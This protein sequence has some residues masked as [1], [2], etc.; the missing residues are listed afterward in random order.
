MKINNM[1]KMGCV[2]LAANIY[3][4]KTPLNVMLSVTDRCTAHCSYCDIPG[5]GLKELDKQIL[6]DLINQICSLGCQRL[7]IWGGEPLVRQ[8]IG[9]IIDYAKNRRL[10]VTMDSNGH[11]LPQKMKEIRNLDHL[12]LSLDGPQDMHD[13]NRG[14]GSFQKVMTAI[15]VAHN[16]VPFWTITV[17]TKYNL[18]SIDFILE[19]ARKYN[20]LTT[21]QLLHHNDIL[22][23]NKQ[24]FLPSKNQYRKA[25]LRLIEE[26]KRKAPIAS[27][28]KY[29]ENLLK[30]EDYNLPTSPRRINKL[31]C[32]GGELF[33]N[34]DTDGSVY[35]CSLLIGKVNSLKFSE[36]GFKEAFETISRNGCQACLA[37]CFTEYNYLYSLDIDTTLNWLKNIRKYKRP[38]RKWK[39]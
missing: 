19:Q 30:W 15:E 18:E 26:K 36:K 38:L 1:L 34:V 31:K 13:L 27:S 4:K 10:F 11:L 5:R 25:I 29:L 23:R 22:G 7:G 17:L 39:H 37:S 9:E 16:N 12:I 33:C 21:F 35:P 6:F 24:D 2:A 28:F 32:W 8:D 14:K 20:F 3:K